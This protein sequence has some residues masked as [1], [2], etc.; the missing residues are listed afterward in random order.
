[1]YRTNQWLAEPV[2]MPPGMP[3]IAMAQMDQ[4][5]GDP[6]MSNAELAVFS[7]AFAESGFTGGINWYRNFSRNWEILGAYEQRITQPALMIYGD[8]DMVPKSDTLDQV[9]DELSVVSLPC[10]HW[11]QQERPDETNAAMLEW[12]KE[13]YPS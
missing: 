2:E 8:Y 10:G 5:P 11:I 7:E 6:L 9:V 1:M 4:M 12:V 3:M 13:H